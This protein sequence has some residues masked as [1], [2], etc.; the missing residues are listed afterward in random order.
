MK[1]LL[2]VAI[3][4]TTVMTTTLSTSSCTGGENDNANDTIVVDDT[5]NAGTTTIDSTAMQEA[6]GVVVEAAH[7]SIDLKVGDKTLNFVFDES[8]EDEVS[9]EIGDS[10]T[11]RYY[12]RPDGDSVVQ[13][14][15]H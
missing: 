9:C 6:T 2:Y 3:A 13:V 5:T 14:I 15:N 7:R 10:L 11:I 12:M 4:A 1:K 8:N